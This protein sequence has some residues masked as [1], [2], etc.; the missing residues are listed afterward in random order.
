MDE[1]SSDALSPDTLTNHDSPLGS[2]PQLSPSD[3]LTQNGDMSP[4][5]V[6][7]AGPVQTSWISPCVSGMRV[8][9]SARR[10]RMKIGCEHCNDFLL[11]QMFVFQFLSQ[12]PP[13]PPP[14]PPLLTNGID[15]S[16]SQRLTNGTAAPANS[17]PLT[18]QAK[19]SHVEENHRSYTQNQL[20]AHTRTHT[21]AHARTHVRTHTH[22]IINLD[23]W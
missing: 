15:S 4:S 11:I 20:H 14:P 19:V 12:P 9:L 23:D 18:S 3:M 2:I 13:P 6:T 7:L 21:C 17:R 22:T 5:Q 8:D 16:L 1:D 10:L